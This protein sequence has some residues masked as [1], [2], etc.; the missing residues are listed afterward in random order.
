[1]KLHK[2]EVF[3][4]A[5]SWNFVIFQKTSLYFVKTCNISFISLKVEKI[6]AKY[7]QK[8]LLNLSNTGWFLSTFVNAMKNGLKLAK[9]HAKP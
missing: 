8:D 7:C 3:Q 2:I 1:M 9:F 5:I 6:Y 4:H